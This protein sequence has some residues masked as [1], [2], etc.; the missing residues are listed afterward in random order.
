MGRYQ[1]LA[2]TSLI[3]FAILF[4]WLRY[5]RHKV[6]DMTSDTLTDTLSSTPSIEIRLI[7]LERRH[8]FV[9]EVMHHGESEEDIDRHRDLFVGIK[10][11]LWRLAQVGPAATEIYTHNGRTWMPANK[12]N[13][14]WMRFRPAEKMHQAVTEV[15]FYKKGSIVAA[16]VFKTTPTDKELESARKP[17]ERIAQELEIPVSSLATWKRIEISSTKYALVN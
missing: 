4:A 5:G 14:W 1:R 3:V 2:V 8:L 6:A 9:Y 12:H 7:P 11:D 17:I 15:S 10:D 16:V 13:A